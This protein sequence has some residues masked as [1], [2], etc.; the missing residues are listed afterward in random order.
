[1]RGTSKAPRA[2]ARGSKRRQGC[3]AI[4]DVTLHRR[5]LIAARAL[6]DA[7]QVVNAT[8]LQLRSNFAFVVHAAVLMIALYGLYYFPYA[9]SSEAA[10]LIRLFLEAQA[11][12]AGFLI[13]LFDAG[14]S[15]RGAV[16]SGSFPLE[17]V[18]SCSALD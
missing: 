10:R 8:A 16:I 2:L 17:I 11:R 18:R 12:F 4:G 9:P 6:E 1:M 7:A 13:G 3:S 14:A 15:V 5:H